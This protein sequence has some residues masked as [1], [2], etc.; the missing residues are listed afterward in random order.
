[1]WPHRLVCPAYV[2]VQ[3]E[4]TISVYVVTT[5]TTWLRWSALGIQ[6]HS[7]VSLSKENSL[8]FTVVACRQVRVSR[9]AGKAADLMQSGTGPGPCQRRRLWLLLATRSP[10]RQRCAHMRRS[11]HPAS[12]ML[13][14]PSS[15]SPPAAPE[16]HRA[17]SPCH[18][19]PPAVRQGRTRTAVA[20][21]SPAPE[22]QRGKGGRLGLGRGSAGRRDGKAHRSQV[23]IGA[24]TSQS[25][26]GSKS[27]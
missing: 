23:S 12:A 19:W 20:A 2:S 10:A 21:A 18:C 15:S 13:R 7:C 22:H 1:V 8:R 24:H 17:P 25:H 3:Q 16:C 11:A 9:W 6:F 26:L 4:V 27:G 5:V 14:P